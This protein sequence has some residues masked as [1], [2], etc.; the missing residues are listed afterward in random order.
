PGLRPAVIFTNGIM[1][2]SFQLSR[3]TRQGS[4]LSP[5]IFTLFLEP[6]AIPLWNNIN[7]TGVRAGEVEHK[8][9]SYAH[10]SLLVPENL[11]VGVPEICSIIDSF[12]KIS[13]YTI[14][15]AMPLSSM[16][17]RGHYLLYLGIELTRCLKKIMEKHIL[18]ILQTIQT[19]LKNWAKMNISLLGKLILK[20]M[21]APKINYIL[22][23]LP[24]SFPHR[25]LKKFNTMRGSFCMVQEKTVD[26][27]ETI[28]L[29]NMDHLRHT[30]PW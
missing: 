26:K 13:G 30:G 29:G 9:F 20:M 28:L 15:W 1:S 27:W 18:P 4:P 17:A 22:Y 23:M 12:S 7:I 16:D 14:N 24:L 21:I 6:L 5:L 8:L 19:S 11:E 10:D 2:F 25:L 3:G